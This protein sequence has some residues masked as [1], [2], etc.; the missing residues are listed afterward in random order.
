MQSFPAVLRIFNF[1]V[2]KMTEVLK[3]CRD[4]EHFPRQA[5][6]LG[7]VEKV[8]FLDYQRRV[9]VLAQ[10]QVVGLEKADVLKVICIKVSITRVEAYG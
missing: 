2:P 10:I 3:H 5:L 9:D 4:S 7:S 6:H 8:V 1:L